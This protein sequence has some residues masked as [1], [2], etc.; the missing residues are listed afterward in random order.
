MVKSKD[1]ARLPFGWAYIRVMLFD[2]IRFESARRV[3]PGF[4]AGIIALPLR[5]PLS[6]AAGAMGDGDDTGIEVVVEI[7]LVTDSL[8]DVDFD[9][10]LAGEELTDVLEL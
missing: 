7:E 1:A 6:H 2:G 5:T 9:V 10:C 3:I 8:A 4:D